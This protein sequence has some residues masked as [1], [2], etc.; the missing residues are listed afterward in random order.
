MSNPDF[1]SLGIDGLLQDKLHNMGI[2]IPTP[3]Q[4]RTIPLVMQGKNLL[5]QSPT[6]TGK[7][8]AYLA[9]LLM[10]INTTTKDLECIILVPSR[11][12]AMQTLRVGKELAKEDIR[13]GVLIGGTNT[14]RQLEQLKSK[15]KIV[16]GTPGRVLELLRKR[17]IN[18]QVIKSIVVDEVDKMLSQGFFDDVKEILKGTL[19]TRQT[20]FY[21][22]TTPKEILQSLPEIVDSP[23]V[24]QIR[25]EAEIPS[26]IEH[27]Y[28]TVGKKNK[29]I[30]LCKLLKLYNPKKAMV[31]LQKNGGADPLAKQLKEKGVAVQALHSDLPQ[32]L[33]KTILDNFRKGKI[34]VLVTT[35]L[36]ARGI[37]IP[38]V[39]YIFNFDLPA[40]EKH[41]L[42]RAGRT[43]RAGKKGTAISLIYDEQEFIIR[44][45]ARM[46]NIHFKHMGYKDNKV[47]HLMKSKG[48]G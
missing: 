20:L 17:K 32:N 2:T 47:F 27:L 33:R 8:I 21:S 37:D 38:G 28:F 43:G 34:R 9:P 1:L 40:D 22:A 11:E 36:L 12:L 30:A 5:V 3:V 10:S 39:D 41:Y 25:G 6:G 23:V 48:R 4:K 24:I 19:K 42:H 26:L 16:V 18:G 44:K 35:D 29:F 45:Y 31:F 15:P 46:L 13:F 7:T 14:K